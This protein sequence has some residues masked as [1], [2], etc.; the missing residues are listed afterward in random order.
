VTFARGRIAQA[1]GDLKSAGKE[2]QSILSDNGSSRDKTLI[3]LTHYRLAQVLAKQ[4]QDAEVLDHLR[5]VIVTEPEFVAA[6]AEGMRTAVRLGDIGDVMTF[7]SDY[8]AR[9]SATDSPLTEAS[10]PEDWEKCGVENYLGIADL[11]EKKYP[12]AIGHFKK[13]L[14]EDQ[15]NHKARF[16]LALAHYRMGLETGNKQELKNAENSLRDLNPAD[17][18]FLS[19]VYLMRAMVLQAQGKPKDAEADIYFDL[20]VRTNPENAKAYYNYGQYC[21]KMGKTKKAEGNYRMAVSID[22]NYHYARVEFGTLL[23]RLERYE[24]SVSEMGKVVKSSASDN[25]KSQAF[26]VLA[27]YEKK[28]GNLSQAVDY[29]SEAIRLDPA[30]VYAYWTLGEIFDEDEEPL[31]ALPNYKRALELC[32]HHC[33]KGQRKQ[34]I[35]KLVGIIRRLEGGQK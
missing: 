14:G 11:M 5:N 7:L 29:E 23:W 28:H 30:N 22:Q 24:E 1:K 3:A 2:F 10:L 31:K 12:E 34:H 18:V 8:L 17:K 16:N 19:N 6:Y 26:N 4:G 33:L 13:A 21:F 35:A 27:D 20:A 15:N 9:E 32:P 25:L